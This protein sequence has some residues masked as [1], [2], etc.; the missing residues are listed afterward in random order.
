MKLRSL[1]AALLVAAI[2]FGTFSAPAFAGAN[3]NACKGKDK[4]KCEI[5]EV[6]WTLVLPAASIGIAATYYLIERRRTD[7]GA[8]ADSQG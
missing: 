7:D 2:L 5:S 8:L 3:E 4:K 6:P 1:V